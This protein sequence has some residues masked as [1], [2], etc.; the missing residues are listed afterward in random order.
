MQAEYFFFLWCERFDESCSHRYQDILPGIAT[1]S[2]PWWRTQE[3][4]SWAGLHPYFLDNISSRV[5][6]TLFFSKF[7]PVY[8]GCLDW[9]K[10]RD[11]KSHKTTPITLCVKN[12]YAR[13]NL[14][15]PINFLTVHSLQLPCQQ[16]NHGQVG[17][18]ELFR[19]QAPWMQIKD[20]M[21]NT[22]AWYRGSTNQQ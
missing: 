9:K 1:T 22:K 6:R 18:M 5:Y 14:I 7:S 8:L 11:I 16:R 17:C 10:G 3:R 20:F 4:A 2:S 19:Y 13:V 21:T 15:L 12:D